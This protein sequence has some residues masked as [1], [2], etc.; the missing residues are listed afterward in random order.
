[1]QT[2]SPPQLSPEALARLRLVV[3][4]LA[5][6][7]LHIALVVGLQFGAVEQGSRAP[8]SVIEA[9]LAPAAPGE[10]PVLIKAIDKPVPSRVQD[11]QPPP[12]DVAS[13]QPT[14]APAPAEPYRPGMSKEAAG[15]TTI[16]ASLPADATY[17]VLSE[18]D[19]QPQVLGKPPYPARAEQEG[20]SG[21]V[22]V[23]VKLNEFGRVDEATILEVSPQGYGL[24][25]SMLNF[26]QSTNFKPAF[27]KG[28]AVRSQF[29]WVV[30]FKVTDVA[31]NP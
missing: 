27:R 20:K 23:R 14:P 15:A 21:F 19:M 2:Q 24:E 25:E 29:T 16:D 8:A 9:R 28:R 31:P 12:V 10:Q 22:R 13:P 7:A 26:L 6:L 5:S 30:E 18:L 3:T 4:L 11:W 1:M 17:H